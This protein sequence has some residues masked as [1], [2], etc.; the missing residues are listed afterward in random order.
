[1][2]YVNEKIS[3]DIKY[4]GK[5]FP[6]LRKNL[7]N[8]AKTYYPSTF[9]DFNE[10]SPG[11][12][13]LETTAY[14]G[15]V[16]SF[17]LDKQFKES[18][19]PYA[20]ER[21]NINLLSQA[22]GYK[23]KQAVASLVDV[24]IYQTVPSIGSGN[25]NRPDFKYALAIKGGMRV[26][27]GNGTAFRREAPIDFSISGSANPTE[28]SVFTTDE[29]TGE[30]TFYLLRKRESFQ[31]GNRNSQTFTVGGAQ[32]YLQ[33]PL[34]RTNI[35]SIDKVTDSDG[36]EWSEVPFIAQDTVF[37][38]INNNQ[39]NDPEFTQY[40]AETPY[41]LKL[42]KTSK[43]FTV[44]IREDSKMI[45]EFGS[46]TSTRPDEEIVPNPLNAG[47]MLPTATPM[48]RTFIDPSNF[49]FTKAYGEAP[50][51]T[52]LTV[53]YST[54]NG[55]KDNVDSGN[56]TDIDF[57]QFI[58]NGAGVDKSLFNSTKNSVAATN[59]TPAQG[60]RGAET[61]EEIRNN[62][63]AFFNAQGRVVSKD[64]YMIRT[65]TMPSIYGTV[66][67]V[68]ATQDEKLNV[69]QATSRIRNPFAVSLYTL[70]YN[71]DK[72]L[73]TSNAATKENIKEYLSPYRLLTDSVTI[74]NAHII[75]IGID[76]EIISLPG[77][78]SN[79]VL[80]RC[81][82][83]MK[84]IFNIDRWQINQPI[85]LADMYTELAKIKG[86]QSIMN[87]EVFNLHD[88]QAGYSGN[89][90]DISHA[91][92]NEVIYPSLDPSIFEVKYPNSNIKG[93]IV[94]I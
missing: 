31:S 88:K 52:T 57:V 20:T 44:K 91:T 90:Y 79:D 58:S 16:L 18:L 67:K 82:S 3:K 2:S 49:M 33:L 71:K 35:I 51:N 6:T 78:N 65:L 24:D 14:V 1:M 59:P 26:K 13:F 77:F 68:Y 64:D 73:T 46:G 70:S 63:L 25:S 38:R 17:Y 28:V 89:I 8:F 74:K 93:R 30:P 32:A 9:N 75:N 27:S 23:P 87:T 11:M 21:K 10:S 50:S 62:A 60:G 39:Y 76:F 47:S 72:Q 55:V 41:L 80:L 5:D 94:N 37:K 15:D 7:I 86:V 36:N 42:K 54:G 29:T 69:S 85:I 61:V 4:I 48:S 45:L 19:L 84:E 92:R 43:R 53:E 56:I 66:A 12:M 22:L 83:K 40:N 81:I 34:N